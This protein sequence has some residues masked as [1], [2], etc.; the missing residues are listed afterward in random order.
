ML[1]PAKAAEKGWG[2]NIRIYTYIIM[3]VCIYKNVCIY[4]VCIYIC[5]INDVYIYIYYICNYVYICN[6]IINTLIQYS[7]YTFS[8]GCQYRRTYSRF[9]L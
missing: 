8:Y 9:M 6:Y 3:Y 4:I 7:M 1:G 5:I 2:S